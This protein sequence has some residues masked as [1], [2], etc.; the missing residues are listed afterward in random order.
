MNSKALKNAQMILDLTDTY[1]E[2]LASLS[3]L[4][5]LAELPVHDLSEKDLIERLLPL[6]QHTFFATTSLFHSTDGSNLVMNSANTI[7]CRALTG[8]ETEIIS[9]AEKT[10]AIQH[11]KQEKHPH[12][13]YVDGTLD[14]FAAPLLISSSLVGTIVICCK[15]EKP[16]WSIRLLNLFS[17]FI[18]HYIC[19]CRDAKT[20]P[21]RHLQQD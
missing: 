6:L 1:E 3:G 2:L 13:G 10:G 19:L 11:R 21:A 20:A 8:M 5:T 18:A 15:T 9:K 12:P 7:H 16:E 17:N 14:M 4:Y